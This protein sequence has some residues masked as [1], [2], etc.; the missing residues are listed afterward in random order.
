MSDPVKPAV[1]AQPLVKFDWSKIMPILLSA[2]VA[3]LGTLQ[4][5]SNIDAPPAPV[6]PQVEVV[7]P[8]V[9]GPAVVPPVPVPSATVVAPSVVVP[10]TPAVTL[11]PAPPTVVK[12]PKPDKISTTTTAKSAAEPE[13]W[14]PTDST[15]KR[16]EAA[17]LVSVAAS[18]ADGTYAVTGVPKVGQAYVERVI[19]VVT[20][21]APRP[22]PVVVVPP[23]PT[24]P[25]VVVP[26]ET[27]GPRDV[28]VIH[29]TADKRTALAIELTALR[30]GENDSYIKSNK[31]SLDVLDDDAILADGTPD[32]YVQGLLKL[33]GDVPLPCVFYIDKAANK[34]INVARF[35][36]ASAVIEGLKASGG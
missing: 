23:K 32:P 4:V 11:T 8:A 7:V 28:V 35:T 10:V 26:P 22:P 25:V 31:H 34:L 12:P 36:T 13:S 5:K 21:T 14:I 17:S 30:V 16:I 1:P 19:S 15:G 24:P 2:L 18:M 3:I 29:E 33:R 27:K 20:L 6:A 9:V